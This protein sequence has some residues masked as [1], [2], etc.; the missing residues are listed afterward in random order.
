M[1]T[2]KLCKSPQCNRKASGAKYINS[3]DLKPVSMDLV[4]IKTARSALLVENPHKPVHLYRA[5]LRQAGE[6]PL[7]PNTVILWCCRCKERTKSAPKFS[8]KNGNLYEDNDAKWT[9]GT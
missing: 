2:T 7:R 1:K 9:Y 6:G 3:V 5:L 8:N 4:G